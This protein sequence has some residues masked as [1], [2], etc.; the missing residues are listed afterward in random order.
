ME[1]GLWDQKDLTHLRE[2]RSKLSKEVKA[3]EVK[4]KYLKEED[5][6]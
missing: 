5:A 4:L 6:G 2:E 3:L 1:A